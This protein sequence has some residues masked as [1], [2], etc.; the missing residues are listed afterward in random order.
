MQLHAEADMQLDSMICNKT[1]LS[2]NRVEG[3]PLQPGAKLAVAC[4]VADMQRP[5]PPNKTPQ[6]CS[7]G[8]QMQ[9]RAY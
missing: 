2:C 5:P 7:R 3:T 1:P 6:S 8:Q 9:L 4:L